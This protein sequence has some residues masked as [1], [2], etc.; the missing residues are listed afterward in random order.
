MPDIRDKPNRIE[1]K[2]H[3]NRMQ[4]FCTICCVGGTIC[5]HK[6]RRTRCRDCGGKTICEHNRRRDHCMGCDPHAAL[7][8]IC[9]NRIYGALKDFDGT[10]CKR[11]M[12]YLGCDIATLRSHLESKFTD[13][14]SWDNYGK[15]WHVDHIVPMLF[16]RRDLTDEE[17]KAR[18]HY[19]NLQPMLATENT[20]KGNRYSGLFTRKAG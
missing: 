1:L 16:E 15:L 7:T 13:N 17:F 11:T 8:N 12:E 3:H 19:T 4:R 9:R 14:M 5:E 10:K 20:S 6:R 18:F 2:C